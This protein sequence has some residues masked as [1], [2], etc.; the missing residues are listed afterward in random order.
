VVDENGHLLGVVR[1]ID[2]LARLGR[3][4]VHRPGP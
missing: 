3:R 4:G 2:L 1:R